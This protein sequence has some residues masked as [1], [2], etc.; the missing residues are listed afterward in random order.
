M[1]LPIN[2]KSQKEMSTAGLF[3]TL[4]LNGD[5]LELERK[6]RTEGGEFRRLT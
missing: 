6:A 5:G 4:E 2:L 3:M 1:H